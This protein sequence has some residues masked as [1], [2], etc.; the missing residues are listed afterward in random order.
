MVLGQDLIFHWRPGGS[1]YIRG[2]QMAQ[3]LGARANCSGDG[4]HIYVKM[5]PPDDYAPRAYLDIIDAQERVSWLLRQPKI[6]VIASSVSSADYLRRK[7]GRD[8][9]YLIPQHHCNFE[10]AMVKRSGILVAGVVGGRG[11]IQC[12]VAEIMAVL[13]RFGIEFRWL[14]RYKSR[15]EIAAFYLELDLQIVWR[16]LNRPLKNPLKIVNAMSFGIATISYSELAYQE[17]TSYYWPATSMAELSA[18]VEQLRQGFD[19]QR[20]VERAELYHIEH[21]ARLYECLA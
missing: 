4:I 18:S 11:A 7:L 10:R 16:K 2:M 12:D 9:I 8:D 13:N 3:Y 21:I 1:G 20:L 6:G 15:E 5:Q 17:V 14:R 19:R